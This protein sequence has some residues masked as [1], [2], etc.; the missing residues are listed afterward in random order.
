MN[1]VELIGGPFDGHVQE[2]NNPA[3]LGHRILLPVSRYVFAQL[4]GETSPSPTDTNP[5]SM[6]MY[7]M[8]QFQSQQRITYQFIGSMCATT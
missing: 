8:S 6:A 5:T 7:E 3:V 4:N 1:I 2:V